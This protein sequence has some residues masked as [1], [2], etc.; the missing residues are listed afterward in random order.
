MVELHHKGVLLRIVPLNV[1]LM[2]ITFF[3]KNK[4]NSTAW[5]NFA[6]KCVRL[7]GRVTTS[8]FSHK[9]ILYAL[10]KLYFWGQLYQLILKDMK[11]K[12]SG[13]NTEF[14]WLGI[15]TIM[16]VFASLILSNWNVY[17]S[18]YTTDMNPKIHYEICPGLLIE[19]KSSWRIGKNTVARK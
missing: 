14:L 12:V 5:E 11:W 13:N 1:K 7:D 19:F 18:E 8:N 6:T 17:K 4:L 15:L 10:E 16:T 9:L 3:G 2:C